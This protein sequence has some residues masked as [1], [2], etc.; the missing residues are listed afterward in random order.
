MERLTLEE[1]GEESVVE[2]P[3]RE[4]MQVFAFFSPVNATAVAVG[5]NIGSAFSFAGALAV[6]NVG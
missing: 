2:L 4:A 6:A 3:R 1:L 5:A